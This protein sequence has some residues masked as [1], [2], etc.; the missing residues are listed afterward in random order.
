MPAGAVNAGDSGRAKTVVDADAAADD[1]AGQSAVAVDESVPAS[2]VVPMTQI[3]SRR[4]PL[5]HCHHEFY[6]PL[7]AAS[8]ISNTAVRFEQNKEGAKF[9]VI[10][11]YL[12]CVVVCETWNRLPNAFPFLPLLLPLHTS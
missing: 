1:G 3:G 8:P 10:P 7:G 12:S 2:Y 11:Q 5:V 6:I 9:V 4:A